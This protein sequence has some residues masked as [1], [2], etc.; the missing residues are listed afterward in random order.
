[1]R[2]EKCPVCG[3][4]SK[5]KKNNFSLITC[6]N[7]RVI[8]T[9][10]HSDINVAALYE[11]EVY[12]VVDNRKSIFEKIIF[13]ESKKVIHSVQQLLPDSK[14]IRCLDFG[15]GKGQFLY[16]TQLA[17]WEALGVETAR[18]RARFAIE[19]YGVKVLSEI[20]H[21]GQI[22]A[23]NFDVITL[24]HVLEHLPEPLEMLKELCDKNLKK[25]GILVI[26]VPNVN[27]WQHQLA[28][29]KW[30][31][32]DIPKHLS[33]W[34]E[35][36]LVE[37]VEALGYKLAKSQYFSLHLGVLGSLSTLLGKL[38]YRGNVIYDL[39]NKKNLPMLLG[40]ALVLPLSL[41]LEIFALPFR[42]TGILRLYFKKNES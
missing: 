38:G 24:F 19:K 32:L 20:Y 29:E 11:D 33:H 30:M 17:G 22:D 35:E 14:P 39:K 25:G 3:A 1:M 26:E 31:H 34:S 8:W 40:V 18:E 27:S 42:K 23:G 13:Q 2:Q 21:E 36:L 5:R 37:K 4:E 12:A 9:L 7:C 16:Q 41:V 6:E 15:S 10:I 28:G